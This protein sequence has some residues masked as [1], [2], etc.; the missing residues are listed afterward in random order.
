MSSD[1]AQR[2]IVKPRKYVNKS[3]ADKKIS[4]SGNLNK[5]DTS[6]TKKYKLS[7]NLDVVFDPA[8]GISLTS[9]TLKIKPGKIKK[10]KSGAYKILIYVQIFYYFV[11]QSS[12]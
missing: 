5:I 8:P 9:A 10:Y 11:C 7:N 2:Y 4:F 1:K 3:K 12:C 6:G